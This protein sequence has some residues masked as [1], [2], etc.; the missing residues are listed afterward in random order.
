MNKALVVLID[1]GHLKVYDLLKSK[2]NKKTI[3][4]VRSSENRVAKLRLKDKISDQYGRF[5]TG[6]GE[7]HNYRRE[8]EKRFI[9]NIAGD[10]NSLIKNG[11]Y[12]NW[13][14]ASEKSINNKVLK[15]LDPEVKCCLKE[16]IAADLTNLHKMELLNRFVF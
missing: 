8:E 11:R 15:L 13:F 9:K 7:N 14:L 12:E 16:N 10:I 1:K 4:L 6:N 3:N 2:N 5:G